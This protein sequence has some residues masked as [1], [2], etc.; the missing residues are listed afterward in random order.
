MG[1]HRHSFPLMPGTLPALW[2]RDLNVQLGR[3]NCSI[4][5][6]CSIMV[7]TETAVSSFIGEWQV[8]GCVMVARLFQ[9]Y[10]TVYGK[11][12]E[13]VWGG[14]CRVHLG[15][16]SLPHSQILAYTAPHPVLLL[17]SSTAALAAASDCPSVKV[18]DMFF[19]C[20]LQ[21]LPKATEMSHRK[22]TCSHPLCTWS[23]MFCNYDKHK[24]GCG[25][26]DKFRAGKHERCTCCDFV[27]AHSAAP[28]Q[29][30]PQSIVQQTLAALG[31]QGHV[32]LHAHMQGE[33][34]RTAMIESRWCV[35]LNF[36][37]I[38]IA[39]TLVRIEF[40]KLQAYAVGHSQYVQNLNPV[41]E[42]HKR[43]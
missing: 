40:L 35:L 36:A 10:Q 28:E 27:P 17:R 21:F 24:N 41:A 32:S 20:A 30:G 6:P 39:L 38:F 42:L 22:G 9:E 43:F 13:Y 1:S 5:T 31:P 12:C 7:G 23:G 2:F 18:R 29:P 8:R 26:G 19:I 16:N 11:V 15:K 4:G 25:I 34:H 37:F 14:G 33:F 3:E